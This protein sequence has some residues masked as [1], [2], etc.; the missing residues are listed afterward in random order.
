M[1]EGSHPLQTP[2]H[3]GL[4][5]WMAPGGNRHGSDWQGR[6]LESASTQAGSTFRFL[7]CHW[8]PFKH[9]RGPSTVLLSRSLGIFSYLLIFTESNTH[10]H[11]NHYRLCLVLSY[12][13]GVV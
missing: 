7:D 13:W 12:Y 10:T 9:T 4:L 11:P 1:L 5:R 2:F 3:V 6:P 8:L